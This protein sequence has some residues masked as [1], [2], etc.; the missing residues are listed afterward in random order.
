MIPLFRFGNFMLQAF[1]LDRWLATA[2]QRLI[3]K[4]KT[5]AFNERLT[6]ELL[7]RPRT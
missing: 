7:P 2:T 3:G 6:T 4:V 5:P 1:V